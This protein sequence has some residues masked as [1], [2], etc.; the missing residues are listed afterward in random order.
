MSKFRHVDFRAPEYCA[1]QSLRDAVYRLEGSTTS[2]WR[3]T[4]GGEAHLELGP[5]YRLLRSRCCGVCSTDLDRHHLPFPLPQI[6]GHEL[7]A[8]DEAGG[9]HVVEINASHRARGL[10]TDCAYCG[11]GLDHHCPDRLVLGIHDLPGG[12]GPWVLAPIASVIAL[13]DSLPDESAVL[14][15]PFAAAL[16]GVD[17]IEPRAGDTI[18]VLG[19]RRLGQLMLAALSARRRATGGRWRI[20]GLS[21]HRGLRAL[22]L[23]LGADEALAPP[24]I[25]ASTGGIADVVVDTTA[26]P[27]GLVLA[28]ALAGREVHLKSTH[29]QPG[30]GLAY[31][32]ELVVDE[33]SLV[34]ITEADVAAGAADLTQLGSIRPNGRALVAWLSSAPPPRAWLERAELIVS[35]DACAIFDTLASRTHDLPAAD[36]AVVDDARSVDAALR[37]RARTERS[38]VRPEGEIWIRPG[39]GAGAAASPLVAAIAG[40]GLRL[41]SS[42]C[43]SFHDALA[44]LE[45]D[46]ELRT[47]LRRLITHRFPASALEEALRTARGPDCIKVLVEHP[48]AKG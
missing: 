36:V 47:A 16:R 7:V 6:T 42:R 21:R 27:D 22:A 12:F 37:P 18:A 11:V 3:I 38:L 40:R 46:A 41:S 31:P 20:V 8:E 1:D 43:G 28:T 13:P 24:A 33:I 2:G 10:A 26:S 32:T 29:G 5:G 35:T 48:D 9:R 34:R 39:T 45:H 23:G 25:D 14:I 30:G 4:R 44:L 15:E 19:T 17:R